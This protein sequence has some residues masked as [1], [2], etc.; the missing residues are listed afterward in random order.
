MSARSELFRELW[1]RQEVAPPEAWLRVFRHPEV[2]VLRLNATCLTMPGVTE[3][4][5][6]VYVPAGPEDRERVERLDSLPPGGW[7]HTCEA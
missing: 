2:G 3:C 7:A 1:D 4:Y 6:V 5:I